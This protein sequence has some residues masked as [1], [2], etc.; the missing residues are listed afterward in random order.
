MNNKNRWD[1]NGDE[2]YLGIAMLLAFLGAAVLVLGW[3]FN[4]TH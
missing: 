1:L 3:V 4:Y 2:T